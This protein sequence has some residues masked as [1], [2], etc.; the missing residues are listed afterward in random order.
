[1]AANTR[2]EENVVS[3]LNEFK[4]LEAFDGVGVTHDAVV[5]VMAFVRGKG[6]VLGCSGECENR[7]LILGSGLG[8]G[9][10]R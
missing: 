8:Q 1:M 9:L 7:D 10:R 5:H 3:A 2:E 6:K 4:V